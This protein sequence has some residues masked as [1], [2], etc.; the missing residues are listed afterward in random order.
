MIELKA[1]TNKKILLIFPM[2]GVD[3]GGINIHLP[4]SLLAVASLLV[5]RGDEVVI[6]DQR[7]EKNFYEILKK[8][9]KEKPICAGLSYMT[10]AQLISAL[11]I[12]NFIK[13]H[14]NVPIVWG[15]IH[16]TLMPEQTLSNTSVDIVVRGEG[17]FSFLEVVEALYLNKSLNG[18]NGI[19][20]RDRGNIYHNPEREFYDLNQLPVIPYE[21]V[22]CEKY[23]ITLVSEKK[24]MDIYTSRGC[25]YNCIF[26]YNKS[27]NKS[28]YRTKNID[29]VIKEIE[30]L[31]KRYG[32]DCV[33]IYDDNFLVDIE[34]VYHFCNS[35]MSK[36]IVSTW[37]CIG[38]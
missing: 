1:K 2:T 8:F 9:L 10:G 6:L 4:M 11:S 22:D 20:W 13:M 14:S 32:I 36:K 33:N 34:R 38:A 12:S 16:P 7:V 31:V 25:P 37:N 19:S 29:L 15:G 3:F 30:W 27:F 28:I 17:E 26:C 18:I 5:E 23:I 35:L 21:L 24:S